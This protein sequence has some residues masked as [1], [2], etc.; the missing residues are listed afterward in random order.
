MPSTY[1]YMLNVIGISE[2]KSDCK[3][4][5]CNSCYSELQKESKA[6]GKLAVI[7]RE[8]RISLGLPVDMVKTSAVH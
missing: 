7:I 1:N 8:A 6:C 2:Y 4:I 5:I 3:C